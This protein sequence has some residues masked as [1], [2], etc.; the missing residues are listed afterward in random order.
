[1]T[2]RVNGGFNTSTGGMVDL[3]FR[4][5]VKGYKRGT[6]RAFCCGARLNVILFSA[7]DD[8][9]SVVSRRLRFKWE[10]MQCVMN[11][12]CTS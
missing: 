2:I 12:F 4:G 5:G 8:T 6:G 11:E 1:M 7:S 3:R 9:S 10:S